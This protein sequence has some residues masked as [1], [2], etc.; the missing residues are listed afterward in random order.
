M[1]SGTSQS[2]LP[3]LRLMAVSVPN[4]GAVQ[5][6][7]LLDSQ[8]SRCMTYGVPC[9]S[10][11]SLPTRSPLVSFSRITFQVSR[12]ISLT[13]AARRLLGTM[14]MPRSLS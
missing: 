11:N 5:G 14:A 7:R 2:V 9:M 3:V 1:P 12:G 4:G 6:E 8:I 10:V 13:T